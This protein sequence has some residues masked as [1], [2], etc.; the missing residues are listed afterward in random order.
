VQ[1]CA[2]GTTVVCG[3]TEEELL[4]V[5]ALFGSFD[6]D[7]PIPVVLEDATVD[8]VVFTLRLAALGI[9]LNKVFVWELFLRVLVE[10]LHV[11]VL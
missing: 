11:R 7:I 8:D 1:R 4:L 10:I 6:E 9:G 2:V 5:I 3:H